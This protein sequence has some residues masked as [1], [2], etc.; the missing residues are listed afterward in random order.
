MFA[1]CVVS[2]ELVEWA[3]CYAVPAIYLESKVL[4]WSRKMVLH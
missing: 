2:L 3:W 4:C 1:G